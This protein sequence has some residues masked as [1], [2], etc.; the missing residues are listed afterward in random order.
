[1][2]V[3]N[4][5]GNS[6]WKE[7]WKSDS[8]D[9]V[10][11]SVDFSPW[12]IL[13][14]THQGAAPVR[15][16]S[17]KSTIAL[18]VPRVSDTNLIGCSSRTGVPLSSSAVNTRLRSSVLPTIM[19]HFIASGFVHRYN[20]SACR[21]RYRKSY[22]F[23]YRNECDVHKYAN[24]SRL[25]SGIAMSMLRLTKDES[26]VNAAQLWA[27]TIVLWLFCLSLLVPNVKRIS[28]WNSA[29][30]RKF[31]G[32]CFGISRVVLICSIFNIFSYLEWVR[33]TS[34]DFWDAF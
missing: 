20:W 2:Y 9:C 12:R 3:V 22:I 7:L 31:N 23:A 15:G 30:S 26:V 18:L 6:S 19:P 4:F 33:M 10:G 14:L 29:S 5:L 32:Y 28:L 13:K 1:M 27:S 21:R 34:F 17:L 16:Q 11:S 24:P 25:R 8:S